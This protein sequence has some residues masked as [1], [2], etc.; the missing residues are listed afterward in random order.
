MRR[1]LPF[2]ALLSL[3]FAPAPFPKPKKPIDGPKAIQGTWKILSRTY[4]GR[5]VSHVVATVEVI[6]GRWT[7]ANATGSWRANWTISLSGKGPPWS[8]DAKSEGSPNSVSYGICEIKGDKLTRCYSRSA[9]ERPNDF[10]GS[11]PGRWLEVYQRM[12]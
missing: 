3:A 5:T 1:I 7:Y 9:A 4:E 2:I 12:K 11:K 8:F 6:G 10:D